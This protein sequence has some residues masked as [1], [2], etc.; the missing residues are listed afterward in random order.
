MIPHSSV[1]SS[2]FPLTSLLFLS[3]HFIP[4]RLS[5]HEYQVVCVCVCVFFVCNYLIVG[6]SLRPLSHFHFFFLPLLFCL[7]T[8]I[9]FNH[10]PVGASL[11]HLRLEPHHLP[12]L[13]VLFSTH[14]RGF[15]FFFFFYV[16]VMQIFFDFAPHLSPPCARYSLVSSF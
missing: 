14:P 3:C 16:K 1:L 12:G 8:L 4:G 11:S 9:H 10:L 5:I 7:H 2:P 13:L 15:P 6:S